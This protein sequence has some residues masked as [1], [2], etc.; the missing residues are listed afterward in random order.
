MA[1]GWL[2]A[3]VAEMAVPVQADLVPAPHDLHRQFRIGDDLASRA[4]KGG[5]GA[6]LVEGVEDGR[7]GF[8]VGPVVKGQDDLAGWSDP[9][10]ARMLLPA[11]GSSG[12]QL[13][14]S[15]PHALG[16]HRSQLV[17]VFSE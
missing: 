7:G 14:Q 15:F 8:R 9:L 10:D 6:D 11:P 2:G 4:E 13:V 12:M 3:I 17:G 5:G 1:V 16:E